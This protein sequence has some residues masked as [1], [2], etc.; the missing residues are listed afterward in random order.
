VYTNLELFEFSSTPNRCNISKSVVT[1]PLIY[2]RHVSTIPKT[3]GASGF[4]VHVAGYAKLVTTC[5]SCL[6]QDTLRDRSTGL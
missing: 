4:V 5:G 2:T 1:I 6:V 3:S